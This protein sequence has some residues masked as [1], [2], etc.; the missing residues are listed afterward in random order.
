MFGATASELLTSLVP[1]GLQNCTSGDS[2]V[3]S[4]LNEINQLYPVLEAK[5]QNDPQGAALFGQQLMAAATPYAGMPPTTCA[6]LAS[7]LTVLRDIVRNEIGSGSGAGLLLVAAGIGLA[8]YF[9]VR[10]R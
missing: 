1:E 10:R 9:M 4:R 3:E 2:V 8:V 5:Y 7:R 6:E